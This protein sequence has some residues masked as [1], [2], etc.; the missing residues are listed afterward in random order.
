MK[1][2]DARNSG[3]EGE[4]FG[5]SNVIRV[6]GARQ[7]NLANLD[8]DIPRDKLVIITGLSGSG[9]SSLAFDTIYAE[10]QRRYVESLS[11]YARMFLGIMDKPD[12]DSITGL[13]PAISIDQKSTSRNPRSTVATVTE[14]YDYLRLL[15]ARVGVPHC[16]ICHK[17]VSR[18]SVEDIVNDFIKEAH[19]VKTLVLPI[20]EAKKLGAMALFG[21]KYGAQVR[22]VDM[23]VSKEFCAGTHVSNTSEVIDFEITSIESIGS[24]VFRATAVT[25]P[26]AHELLVKSTENIQNTL[27]TILAKAEDIIASAKN[28][29]IELSFNYEKK[30]LNLKGYRYIL[31]LREEVSKAQNSVKDLE[32]EYNQKKSQS[33]LKSLEKFDSLIEGDKL[34]TCVDVKDTNLIKDMAAALKNNKGLNVVLLAS[35]D[36]AKVTFVC[37][38]NAPYDA[39]QIVKEATKI[40]GG[41]GGGKKD[42]AQAGGRD[43][44]KVLDA[45]EHV[46]EFLK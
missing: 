37:A 7:N 35:C 8:V 19:P 43:S 25:G 21:E 27:N 4:I 30:E 2:E 41:G 38:A 40:T 16:P 12:V 1:D 42:L 29:G 9:K 23:G 33:A 22:V 6:R 20:E 32:K 46:K 14:V 39:C 3:I 26:N 5:D 17:E 31:A 15:F 10:G 11:S 13:S 44:S 24:G 34:F 18:R 45:L 28:E 36:G